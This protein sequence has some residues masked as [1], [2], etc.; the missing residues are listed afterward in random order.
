MVLIRWIFSK[1]L[2]ITVGGSCRF[3]LKYTNFRAKLSRFVV[4]GKLKQSPSILTTLWHWFGGRVTEWFGELHP[5]PVR[6]CAGCGF[7][8]H[9]RSGTRPSRRRGIGELVLRITFDMY[10]TELNKVGKWRGVTLSMSLRP[11]KTIIQTNGVNLKNPFQ[12]IAF[13]RW[14]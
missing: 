7:E 2:S 13:H 12:N 11:K 4:T 1:I 5:W 14:R 9:R 3:S 10:Y 8:S 6:W